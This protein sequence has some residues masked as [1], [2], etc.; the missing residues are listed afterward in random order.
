[1]LKL[2]MA[3]GHALEISETET[4]VICPECGERRVQSVQAR[5]P[6]FR[7]VVQGPYTTYVSLPAMPVLVGVRDGE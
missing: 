7:G 4:S 1:M 6:K 2:R 3:C 5:A